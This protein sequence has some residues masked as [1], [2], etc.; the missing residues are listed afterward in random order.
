M[1]E[2]IAKQDALDYIADLMLINP[3]VELH[4]TQ[5]APFGPIT[6]SI[7]DNPCAINGDLL[8]FPSWSA[9][10]AHLAG[11]LSSPYAMI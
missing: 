8:T 4:V 10:A 5:E 6:L 9:T 1:E 7:G 2:H 3:G 11:I